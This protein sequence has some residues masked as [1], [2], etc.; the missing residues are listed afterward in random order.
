MATTGK[1]SAAPAPAGGRRKQRVKQY[2]TTGSRSIE[3][4][5]PNSSYAK[6]Y[7]LI[8][9]GSRVL[10]LGCGSGELASYLAARGDRVWGVDINSAALAHAAPFC[11]ETRVADLETADLAGLFAG[12][13]FDVVVFADSLEHVREPWNLLQAARSVLDA[14]GRVVASIPNFAHVAVRLAVLSGAMPYRGLGILDDTHVRFFTLNGVASLF[15]ESGFRIQEIARTTLPFGQPSDLVPDVRQLRVPTDIERHVRED[16]ENETLQFVV[17]AVMLPGE[18]DMGA[19][20]GRLHDVEARLE[21]STIGLRNL[22]REQAAALALAQ[23]RGE[24]VTALEHALHTAAA[25]LRAELGAALGTTAVDRPDLVARLRLI[26][27]RQT[28]L[29]RERDDAVLAHANEEQAR[30]RLENQLTHVQEALR[31]AVEQRDDAR[32]VAGEAR[33]QLQARENEL[34]H[35]LKGAQREID[36]LRDA[37]GTAREQV[38]VLAD[39]RARFEAAAAAAEQRAQTLEHGRLSRDMSH[40]QLAAANA[41]RAAL[42][43]ALAHAKYALLSAVETRDNAAAA[44]A[45]AQRRL[46]RIEGDAADVHDALR[47]ALDAAS[48]ELEPFRRRARHEALQRIANEHEALEAQDDG[49]QFWR[50]ALATR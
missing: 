39:D 31:E 5:D 4:L 37:L 6:L 35:G 12:Q 30:R 26:T 17:R 24:R 22:Q 44:A 41:E 7:A 43:N 29:E 20:R 2:Q 38:R 27:T 9:P 14:G 33:A 21:E 8:A 28:E 32:S 3:E 11:V 15:E 13:R 19:I 49:E 48:A 1:T 42:E 25:D 18:W 46:A 23:E 36:E 34:R 50:N 16:P 47:A 45:D 10:D 40:E